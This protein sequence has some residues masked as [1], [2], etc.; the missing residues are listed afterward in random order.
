MCVSILITQNTCKTVTP[1]PMRVYKGVGGRSDQITD[2]LAT[3]AITMAPIIPIGYPF[4]TASYVSDKY[5]EPR[6]VNW[7]CSYSALTVELKNLVLRISG[8]P[9]NHISTVCFRNTYATQVY[10]AT[11]QD[12]EHYHEQGGWVT[13]SKIPRLNYNKNVLEYKAPIRGDYT[14]EEALGMIPLVCRLQPITTSPKKNSK[15]F[16]K[17]MLNKHNKYAKKSPV[18]PMKLRTRVRL[19]MAA[20]DKGLRPVGVIPQPITN[21][22]L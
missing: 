3:W 9:I 11:P 7:K 22:N 17:Q 12:I 20:N 8:I 16:L 1:K 6:Q 2:C 13:T 4:T 14:T 10:D 21:M 15:S 5:K 19:V 18:K